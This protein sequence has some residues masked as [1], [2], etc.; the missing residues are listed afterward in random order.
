MT[1]EPKYWIVGDI[2][3]PFNFRSWVIETVDK[4]VGE[5]LK[6]YIN[7][8][9]FILLELKNNNIFMQFSFG[10]EEELWSK[11]YS[12]RDNIMLLFCDTLE[13]GTL[14]PEDIK[15][16]RKASSVLKSIASDLD[17][18]LDQAEAA[19]IKC[20]RTWQY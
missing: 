4:A 16:G 3:S 13:S 1:Y 19:N 18:A 15:N 14:H 10:D 5:A 7:E 6:H 17:A 2:D 8:P 20:G 11:E 12:L 9:S